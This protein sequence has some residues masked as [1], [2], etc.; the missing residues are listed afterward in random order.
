[1]AFPPFVNRVVPTPDSNARTK[2]LEKQPRVL[3]ICH[4]AATTSLSGILALFQP[5]GRTV[6]ATFAI[7]N[8]GEIVGCVDPSR[9]PWTSAS[10]LDDIAITFECANLST[11]GWTISEK[12][13]QSIAKIAAWMN[14][15]YPGFSIDREHIVGHRE[16]YTRWGESYATACPGGMDLDRVVA[17]AR[18]TSPAGLGET[19]IEEPNRKRPTM[20]LL[21]CPMWGDWFIVPGVSARKVGN[22]DATNILV[23]AGAIQRTEIANDNWNS[24]FSETAGFDGVDLAAPEGTTFLNPVLHG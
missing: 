3:L 6:S 20:F 12:S 16:L 11:T 9:R 4:H 21:H 15:V 5:G 14:A 17:L 24:V 10:K 2:P 19:P 13:Y 23:A 18:V 7:G 22:E 1:M 8:D